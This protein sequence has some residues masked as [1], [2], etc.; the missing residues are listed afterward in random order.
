VNKLYADKFYSDREELIRKSIGE[1]L[2]TLRNDLSQLDSPC[3]SKLFT[4]PKDNPLTIEK[5]MSVSSSERQQILSA[6]LYNDAYWRL[7]AA[8]LT[9]CVGMLNITYSN[10]RSCLETVV[11]AHIIEN[12]DS[13]AQNF[14][15]KGEI[16]PTKIARFIPSNYNE[17]IIELKKKLSDWGVHARLS[18]I[19]LSGL[20]GP[21]TFDKMASRTSIKRE[22][23]L[24]PEFAKAADVCLQI[25][26]NVFILFMFLMYKGTKYRA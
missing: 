25:I 3:T 13:E 23:T 4:L 17:L 16:D 22:Q 9:F 24:N 18:S 11:A 21:N 1:R 15:T 8:Y 20:F 10:L 2:D 26:G 6:L 14:L 5:L 7:E 12:L 19:Q